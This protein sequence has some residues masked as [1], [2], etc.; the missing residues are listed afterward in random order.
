MTYSLYSISANALSPSGCSAYTYALNGFKPYTRAP[1]YQF[2]EQQVDNV[3]LNG[4]TNPAFPFMTG[5]GGWHQVG[6]MGWLGARIIE[7]QLIIQPALPPQIPHVSIRTL[8]FGGAGIKATMNYTHTTITRVDVRQH[9]P[10]NSSQPYANSSMPFTVGFSLVSGQNMSIVM[11][12]TLVIENRRYFDNVTTPG[13]VVQCLPVDSEGAYQPGQF[14]LAAIDG[15]SSTRWQPTIREPSSLTI[16]M[17]SIPYQPLT[18]AS[19]DWG[20]RPAQNARILV[21]NGTS[22]TNASNASDSGVENVHMVTFSNITISKPY[23]A[24]TND[25]VQEYV[26]NVSTFAFASPIW[27]G[28]FALLEISGC[29]TT[30]DELGATVAEF[31][32]F[33]ANGV[34]LLGSSGTSNTTA[35]SV[36]T[37][38]PIS[39]S[40]VVSSMATATITPVSPTSSSVPEATSGGSSSGSRPA[41]G[42][43]AMLAL[44]MVLG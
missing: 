15:A 9:L 8:I 30:G 31:S 39:T 11:G 33:G 14:P 5:A 29:I 42:A 40:G 19:L 35:T 18:G 17:S 36:S 44:V 24:A 43:L 34:G 28:Q 1:W 27:S 4:G 38:T 16:D 12:Q 10:T 41:S 32:L 22:A 13:N 26:G 37:V 20:S 21:W 6:P 7:E 2:S 25:V 23:D 3:T